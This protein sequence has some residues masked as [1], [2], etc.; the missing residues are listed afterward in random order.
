M[1]D[2]DWLT[3]DDI[4]RLLRQLKDE[5]FYGCISFNFRAGEVSL[6]RTE[7]THLIQGNTDSNSTQGR[8]PSGY[9]GPQRRRI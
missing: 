3:T 8:T 6:I 7:R 4:P 5:R 9:T 2:S 1:T